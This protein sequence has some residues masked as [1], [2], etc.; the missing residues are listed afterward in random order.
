M[1]PS[2]PVAD[3]KGYVTYP[4]VNTVTEMTNMIDA[5]RSYEANV[6]TFN[7]SKNMEL[8]ALEVGKSS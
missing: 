8:K 7:A 3:E 5:S 1:I 4:N 2:N 6:T